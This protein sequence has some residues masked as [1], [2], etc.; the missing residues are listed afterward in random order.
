MFII[1]VIV[2]FGIFEFLAIFISTYLLKKVGS[3]PTAMGR[4]RNYVIKFGPRAIKSAKVNYG[5]KNKKAPAPE[6]KK[7]EEKEE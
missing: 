3:H 7:E 2:D 1:L 5:E 4:M 6:I